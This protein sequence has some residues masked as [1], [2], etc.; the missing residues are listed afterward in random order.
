MVLFSAVGHILKPEFY[1]A[2]IPEFIP[3]TAAHVLSA[4]VEFAVGIALLIPKTRKYGALGFM[5]L[6]IAF[7]PIHVWDALRE[8]PAV[9]STTAA[10][11]RLVIQFLLIYTGWSLY[12]KQSMSEE[13]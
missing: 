3:A 10:Y 2:M 12:K 1:A 11:I 8:E 13:M 5:A 7:L 6:M 9:G 4:I